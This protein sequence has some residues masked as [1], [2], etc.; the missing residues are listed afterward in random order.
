MEY[1][2]PNLSNRVV[3]Y[4]AADA[5]AA[6]AEWPGSRILFTAPHTIKLFRDGHADHEVETYTHKLARQ[7]ALRV[8]GIALTWSDA[9]R[10]KIKECGGHPDPDNRDP[11]YL[12]DEEARSLF[13]NPWLVG[14]NESLSMFGEF[15]SNSLIGSSLHVDIHGM[16]ND[17]NADLYLGYR[18][19]Q[20]RNFAICA[21]AVAFEAR[22]RALFEPFL[23]TAGLQQGLKFNDGGFGGDWFRHAAHPGRNTLTQQSTND[24]WFI[25]GRCFQNALQCEMSLNMRNA[26]GG[27][28]ALAE[29]FADLFKQIVE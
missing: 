24:H 13:K 17:H 11:N 1:P 18:A 2:N 29:R 6:G 8:G 15:G 23:A 12:L 22:L 26:L 4:H 28:Q 20:R 25:R 5:A 19:M 7:F 27:S 3:L 21:D 10:A 9:E 16:S 14:F